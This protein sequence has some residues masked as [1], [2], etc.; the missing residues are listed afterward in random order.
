MKNKEYED[1]KWY[2]TDFEKRLL[3]KIRSMKEIDNGGEI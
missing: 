3:H 1:D 2:L